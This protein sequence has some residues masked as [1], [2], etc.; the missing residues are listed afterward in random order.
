MF[1][2]S[3]EPIYGNYSVLDPQ[4]RLMFRCG[5]KK[6]KWYL[7]KGLADPINDRVIRLN[8]IPNGLGYVDDHF[9]LQDRK[10]VCVCC[11]TDKKLSKH[12]VVPYCYR[13]F[14]PELAKDHNYHDVL[15]LCTDCHEL[16]ES[17]H[18]YQMRLALAEK[19]DAPLHGLGVNKDDPIRGRAIK[20]AY[21]L[22]EYGD[23]IPEDRRQE[24]Y[25]RIEA[26]LGCR[27][28]KRR[29][30]ALAKMAPMAGRTPYYKTHGEIVMSKVENLQEFVVAWRR[31]FIETMQPKFMPQGWSIEA[32][33]FAGRT[34]VRCEAV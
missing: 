30:R 19:Y 16:Y 3:E 25:S 18:S 6:F 17:E 4:G 32:D 7:K 20:A 8:F 27:P 1:R 34:Y 24:L 29:I 11:G 10:N 23:A 31:N 9:Y 15:P 33:A 14:F 26:F 2:A 12:H 21:C 28:N 13:K 22:A 5:E